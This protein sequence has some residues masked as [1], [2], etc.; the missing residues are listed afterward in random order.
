[1]KDSD[2]AD[3]RPIVNFSAGPGVMPL[4]VLQKIQAEFLDFKDT[5]SNLMELSHR[6]SEFSQVIAKAE[7]DLREL[8]DIPPEYKVLLMQ[9]G[10]TAQVG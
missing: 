6:S 10:A 8:L 4:P 2:M 7:R 5:Q 3:E 1:M 9:G